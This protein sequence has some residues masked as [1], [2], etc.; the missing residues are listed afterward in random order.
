MWSSHG[1]FLPSPPFVPGL[2][3]SLNRDV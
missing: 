2:A 1:S 3:F